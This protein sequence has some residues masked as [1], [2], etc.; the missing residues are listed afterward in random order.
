ML[1]LQGEGGGKLLRRTS[2][3]DQIHGSAIYLACQLDSILIDQRSRQSQQVGRA[4]SA[5]AD[6]LVRVPRGVSSR[7]SDV[8]CGE[9]KRQGGH[10]S[11][12][13]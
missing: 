5:S 10:P 11:R 9:R 1:R 12:M 7:S 13:I 2:G 3:V 4:A 6:A 8:F